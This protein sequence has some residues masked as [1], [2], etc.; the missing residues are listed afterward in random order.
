MSE[1]RVGVWSALVASV[2]TLLC[3][4][5]PALLVL[6]GFGTTVAALIAAAPW[7]AVLSQNKAWVFFAAGL[8]IVGSRL[9][10]RFVVPRVMVDGAAC[11]PALGR[12][13]RA[14]WWTSVA[15]YAVGFFVAYLLGPLLLWGDG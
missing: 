15:I 4:A 10:V 3:C 9:Y 11:P 8:L 12:V 6:L 5:L 7:L 13:T 1:G 14:A 2:A